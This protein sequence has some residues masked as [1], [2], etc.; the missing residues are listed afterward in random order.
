MFLVDVDLQ[1]AKK[2]FWKVL[3]RFVLKTLAVWN[4]AVVFYVV[5]V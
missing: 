4:K 1:Y 2:F 5:Y 3:D